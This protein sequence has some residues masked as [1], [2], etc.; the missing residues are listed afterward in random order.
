[1]PNFRWLGDQEVDAL[2]AFLYDLDTPDNRVPEP[3]SP[4]REVRRYHHTGYNKFVGADGYPAVRPPW[5]TLSAI[6]LHAGTI[7]W[8]VPLGIHQELIDRGLPPT[9]T[10]N[11]GGPVV[12]AGDLLFIAATADEKIRAFDKHTGR[13]VWSHDLP[14]AGYATPATYAVDGK[15]YLVI[16]CGGGKLGTKSG[17]SWVAFALPDQH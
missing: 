7:R 3:E 16:A 12:T 8:Q 13:E 14:A 15:Q 1:M 4:T 11:Y 10:E 5:G 6:D 2:V 17:D 9:G